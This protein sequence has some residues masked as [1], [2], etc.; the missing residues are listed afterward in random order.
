MTKIKGILKLDKIHAGGVL[1]VP[2]NFIWLKAP[3]TGGSSMLYGV[4]QPYFKST[5]IHHQKWNR[6]QY[7]P[8]LDGLDNNNIERKFM[9]T[10]VRNPWERLLSLY[11]WTKIS[12]SFW[13]CRHK[14]VQ[15]F[16]QFVYDLESMQRKEAAI[17]EHSTPLSSYAYFNGVQFVD[18]IGRFENLQEDF[19]VICD[20]I[21]IPQQKLPQINKSKHKH[22]T[23][24]YDDETKQ[25][26]AEKFAKD[27]E[28]F[29]YKFGER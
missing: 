12:P 21:G 7:R 25:I 4:I 5:I 10:F 15:S 27:I 3:R 8:Y 1:I 9:F 11:F 26:V 24:Y 22:Y 29:G 18:F 28:Y 20:K 19:N 6:E 13:S 17:R 16:T 14:I 23:E 2:D